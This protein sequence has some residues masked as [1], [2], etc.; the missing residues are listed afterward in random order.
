MTPSLCWGKYTNP[1]TA[2][3]LFPLLASRAAISSLAVGASDCYRLRH[4]H[5]WRQARIA[6]L[7][8]AYHENN[9]D[10]DRCGKQHIGIS[11]QYM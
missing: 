9:L 10:T 7:E 4:H 2:S 8:S 1:W 6:I 5:T 11:C 3:T